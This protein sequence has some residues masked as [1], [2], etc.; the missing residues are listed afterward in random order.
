ML[1]KLKFWSFS[2]FYSQVVKKAEKKRK[3]KFLLST[4]QTKFS[5]FSYP[6]FWYKIN[7]LSAFSLQLSIHDFPTKLSIVRENGNFKPRHNHFM[8]FFI[9]PNFVHR[10]ADRLFQKKIWII[11]LQLFQNTE[12]KIT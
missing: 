8:V 7:R 4:F 10:V 9:S 5:V 6:F 11:G 1:Q 12:R 2:I 3:I